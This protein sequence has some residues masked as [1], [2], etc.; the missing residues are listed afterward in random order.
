MSE[1]YNASANA[2]QRRV[3]TSKPR[4]PGVVVM[5]TDRERTIYESAAGDDQARCH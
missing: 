2:I 3:V 4:V 5:P 1:G